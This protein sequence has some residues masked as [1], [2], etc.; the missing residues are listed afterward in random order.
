MENDLRDSSNRQHYIF[1]IFSSIIGILF[2]VYILKERNPPILVFVLSNISTA[3]I[4]GL[5]GIAVSNLIG[6][7]KFK[8]V[9]GRKY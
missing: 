6:F 2:T 1:A 8:S 7:K 9:N 4:G 5:I 3:I